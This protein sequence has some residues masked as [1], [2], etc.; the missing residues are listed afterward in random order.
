MADAHA[1]AHTRRRLVFAFVGVR[2]GRV[3][4]AH[5]SAAAGAAAVRVAQLVA[6]AP[7]RRGRRR[8]DAIDELRGNLLEETRRLGRLILA[9]NAAPRGARQHEP[10][11]RAREAHVAQPALFLDVVHR[12]PT[13]RECGNSPSS[14]PATTTIGNSRPLA[15]CIVISHTRASCAPSAS[16]ASDSSDSRSTNPPSDG[17]VSRVSY[18]RRGGDQFHQVLDAR[19]GFLAALVAQLLQVAAIGRARAAARTTRWRPRRPWTSTQ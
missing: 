10:L 15:A 9:E 8:L 2:R 4:L 5:A 3:A 14:M 17:S 11:A 6:A 19:L 7:S 16:S 1:D 13:A 18:S 12:L